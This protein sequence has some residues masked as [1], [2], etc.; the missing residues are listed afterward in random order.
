MPVDK[1]S[2]EQGRLGALRRYEVL[3]TPPE[4]GFETV[5]SLVRTV[6]GVP[7]SAV[8]LVDNDR[9]WFKSR[10]GLDLDETP[11]DVA[12]CQHTIR[13]VGPLIVEDASLDDRFRDNPLVRG[14][15]NIASYAGV[16]LKT[17]DGYNIGSLCAMDTRPRSYDAKQIE[18]LQHLATLVVEQ[19]ELRNLAGRDSLTGAMTRGAFMAELEKSLSLFARQKRPAALIMIDIDHFKQVNDRF[20]H[21]AG[22]KAL[23]ALAN[24]CHQ[25]KRPS[26]SF[27]R[28]GGEEF[29]LL[30]PETEKGE[31]IE[32]AERLR[33]QTL[34]IRV[35]NDPPFALTASFGVA[36]LS[37][38]CATRQAILEVA[39][40]ALYQAK[41]TG[42]N[43]VCVG[44]AS[45][46]KAA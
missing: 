15:P 21:P 12:F 31:A 13:Q 19:L 7:M 2:D 40:A 29:A 5:T 9:Q 17:P 18:V 45:V 24:V 14:D 44:S 16:P 11:R 30:L 3:D 32:V 8:S 37:A 25:G 36:T 35:P 38:D 22:D 34:G 26:D 10:Q 1:L 41:R 4:V 23:T 6:L 20:G 39:D 28:L 42:R 43:R 27:G 33:E 46:S